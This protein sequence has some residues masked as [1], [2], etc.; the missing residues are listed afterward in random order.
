MG[1]LLPE[2]GF[3]DCLGSFM[4]IDDAKEAIK[5]EDWYEHY[6]IISIPLMAIVVQDGVTSYD[7][8]SH[9]SLVPPTS[10]AS[11]SRIPTLVQSSSANGA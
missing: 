5:D 8:P 6:Q 10:G 2:G 7:W 4:T 1:K 3:N 9:L 11:C